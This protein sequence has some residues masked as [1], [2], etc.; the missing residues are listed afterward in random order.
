MKWLETVLLEE[1]SADLWTE[2]NCP[3]YDESAHES[4]EGPASS[5]GLWPPVGIGNNV[6]FS[7]PRS[8]RGA[9]VCTCQRT[10]KQ[11]L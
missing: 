10:P 11:G 5:L 1:S 2:L 9:V 4:D 8:R 3:A 6:R 7:G